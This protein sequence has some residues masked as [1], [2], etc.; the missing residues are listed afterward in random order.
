MSVAGTTKCNMNTLL[1]SSG[2]RIVARTLPKHIYIYIYVCMEEENQ[3]SPFY[4]LPEFKYKHIT[5]GLMNLEKGIEISSCW[6]EFNQHARKIFFKKIPTK[7][8]TEKIVAEV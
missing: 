3:R 4:R 2:I 5:R 1:A 8:Q 7:N 6:K